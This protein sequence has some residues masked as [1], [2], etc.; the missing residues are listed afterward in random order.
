MTMATWQDHE[1]FIERVYGGQRTKGSGSTV[2]HK[3]DVRI[4]T[5]SELVE[6]K[7]QG[8]PESPRRTRLVKQLEKVANEAYEEGLDPV[9]AWRIFD[10]S[11]ELAN[12]DGYVDVAIR[13]VRD[14]ARRSEELN[15]AKHDLHEAQERLFPSED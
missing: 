9:L 1:R 2:A 4:S 5:A 3:G 15:D 12:L 11:S 8:N 10:P 13:L 14:D 7:L 6:C